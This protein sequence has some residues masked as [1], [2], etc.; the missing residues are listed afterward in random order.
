MVEIHMLI[1]D[2]GKWCEMEDTEFKLQWV[3]VGSGY[4]IQ[5]TTFMLGR[6]G[7]CDKTDEVGLVGRSGGYREE[8]LAR[9]N[10]I[11]YTE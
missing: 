2:D 6:D 8:I 3:K 7:G 4:T 5:R 9:C 10:R 1:V 11:G